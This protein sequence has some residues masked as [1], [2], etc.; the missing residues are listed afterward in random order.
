MAIRL[1]AE[2]LQQVEHASLVRFQLHTSV[3]Y[4]DW[5]ATCRG[6]AALE[7]GEVLSLLQGRPVLSP[8]L[9]SADDWGPAPRQP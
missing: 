3:G 4:P 7:R 2:G 8:A 6:R 9:R 5:A 1:A